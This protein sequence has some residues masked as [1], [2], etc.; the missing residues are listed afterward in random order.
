MCDWWEGRPTEMDRFSLELAMTGKV[1]AAQHLGQMKLKLYVGMLALVVQ[2][3]STREPSLEPTLQNPILLY[4]ALIPATLLTVSYP[5][6]SPAPVAV[7]KQQAS[8]AQEQKHV[9]YMHRTI[10]YNKDA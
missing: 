7:G 1:S 9:S 10:S 4:A 2:W 8:F 6:T 5:V 3:R